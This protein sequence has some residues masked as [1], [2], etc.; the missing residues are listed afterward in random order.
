MQTIKIILLVTASIAILSACDRQEKPKNKPALSET[1]L[2]T[3]DKNIAMAKMIFDTQSKINCLLASIQ[4]KNKPNSA[5]A[6]LEKMIAENNVVCSLYEAVKPIVTSVYQRIEDEGKSSPD[7]YLF[8]IFV[9]GYDD[10]ENPIFSDELIGLFESKN[11][12]ENYRKLAIKLDIP[13]KSCTKLAG[14]P[15]L[16]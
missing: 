16:E 14:N 4:D 2:Y 6:Q 3:I 12:C 9:R 11:D 13:N 1:K 10:K 7:L 15:F 5:N 8:K